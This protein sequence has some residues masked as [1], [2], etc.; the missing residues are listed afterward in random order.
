VYTWK[1]DA[2]AIAKTVQR[3]DCHRRT[4]DRSNASAGFAAIL[5]KAPHASSIVSR[6]A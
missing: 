6:R 4:F 1:A 2:N 5:A 3:P